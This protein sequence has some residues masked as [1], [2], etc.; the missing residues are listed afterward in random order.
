MGRNKEI[1]DTADAGFFNKVLE[2]LSGM[3]EGMDR[4]LFGMG[5]SFR[6]AE[7]KLEQ[8]HRN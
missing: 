8:N 4:L 2:E 5:P 1:R 3:V 7:G 6:L